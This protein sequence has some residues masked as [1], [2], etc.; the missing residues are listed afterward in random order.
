M[1]LPLA[2]PGRETGEGKRWSCGSV[3]FGTLGNPCIVPCQTHSV[4]DDEL[5]E[6]SGDSGD[7][8]N[9][10]DDLSSMLLIAESTEKARARA[11]AIWNK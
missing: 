5:E 7:A 10:D 3:K 4:S 6:I 8:E 11:L 1:G 2:H 9:V